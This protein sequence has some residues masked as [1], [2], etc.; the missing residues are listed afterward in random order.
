MGR[1]AG[2]R[3]GDRLLLIPTAHRSSVRWP[4]WRS[5]GMQIG[6]LQHVLRFVVVAQDAAGGSEQ[7]LIVAA[8]QQREGCLVVHGN[9]RRQGGVAV[10]ALGRKAFWCGWGGRGRVSLI[11]YM[12]HSMMLAGGV[13]QLTKLAR[14]SR[15]GGGNR[16]RSSDGE[17]AIC[18]AFQTLRQRA[19]GQ[20]ILERQRQSAYGRGANQAHRWDR[21][22]QQASRWRL[23]LCLLAGGRMLRAQAIQRG[24]SRRQNVEGAANQCRRA[25]GLQQG[26]WQNLPFQNLCRSPAVNCLLPVPG[27]SLLPSV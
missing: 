5:P 26:Q 25:G 14:G 7:Q 27:S 21:H 9:A 16:A 8:H 23:A 2:L 22:R 4:V 3:A 11:W 18:I 12:R 1:Q 13:R 15:Q 20:D 10:V 6:F 24:L 17:A 19:T